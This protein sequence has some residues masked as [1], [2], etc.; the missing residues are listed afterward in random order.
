[1]SLTGARVWVGLLAAGCG[2]GAGYVLGRND[3]RGVSML[4]VFPLTIALIPFA[5][6]FVLAFALSHVADQGGGGWAVAAVV[7]MAAMG[8]GMAA[9]AHH[10]VTTCAGVARCVA[11]PRG[12]ATRTA[13]VAG[14]AWASQAGLMAAFAGEG[15]SEVA[16][17]WFGSCLAVVLALIGGAALSR[18]HL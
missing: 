4:D 9:F 18:V 17:G 1:M 2:M 10:E 8:A 11:Y 6:E 5:A 16:G 12:E 3:L 13:A 15:L 14:L 7:L